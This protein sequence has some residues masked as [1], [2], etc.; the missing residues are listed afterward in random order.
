MK[1]TTADLLILQVWHWRNDKH[2]DAD[3]D[4]LRVLSIRLGKLA[5]AMLQGEKY[6]MQAI[7]VA[8]IA[9]DILERK[10][11]SARYPTLDA[12]TIALLCGEIDRCRAK[13]PKNDLM[14]A[15]L[16]EEFG[17]LVETF[18]SENLASIHKEALQ[19]A[20]VAVRIAEE[21][22]ATFVGASEESKQ[23]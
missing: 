15:A 10:T 11:T 3:S 13:F 12:A 14:L 9:L 7:D 2:K 4:L 19:V 22:D 5:R 20:C 17:E 6:G 1:S 23:K 21:G 8:T 16:T 18:D